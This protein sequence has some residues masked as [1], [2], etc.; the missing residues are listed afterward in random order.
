MYK[1]LYHPTV[2]KFLRK[3]SKKDLQTLISKIEK[4]AENPSET[5][6][7]DIKKLAGTVSSYRM[8]HRNFR[9]IYQTNDKEKIIY[10]REIDFRGN[11]Y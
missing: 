6:N 7:L 8:R 5:Q 3:I 1:V 4:L 11:I 9:I 10:I 2:F